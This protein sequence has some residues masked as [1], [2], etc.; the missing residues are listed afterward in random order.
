MRMTKSLRM[1]ETDSGPS[2]TSFTDYE[3]GRLRS[4]ICMG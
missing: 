2:L 3:R 1:S 4:G